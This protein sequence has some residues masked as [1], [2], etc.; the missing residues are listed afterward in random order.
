MSKHIVSSE[1]DAERSI[2]GS[3]HMDQPTN[4]SDRKPDSQPPEGIAGHR[5]GLTRDGIQ[6]DRQEADEDGLEDDLEESED[7]DDEADEMSDL[8]DEEDDGES[9]EEMLE[10][11]QGCGGGRRVDHLEDKDEEAEEDDRDASYYEMLIG[12]LIDDEEEFY[13]RIAEEE[14]EEEDYYDE[15]VFFTPEEYEAQAPARRPTVLQM[16]TILSG[17]FEKLVVQPVTSH[18]LTEPWNKLYSS[19]NRLGVPEVTDS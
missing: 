7:E 18:P 9:L 3:T 5:M 1:T 2:P 15:E 12:E 10:V 8:D 6:H 4:S 11:D 14:E 13:E 19:N 17:F 16:P